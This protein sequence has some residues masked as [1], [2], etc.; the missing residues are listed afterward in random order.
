MAHPRVADARAPGRRRSTAGTGQPPSNLRAMA[1]R[2]ER[3]KRPRI[4]GDEARCRRALARYISGA[5]ELLDQAEG[6]R[7]R[8][9]ASPQRDMLER[10]RH[11]HQFDAIGPEAEWAKN[12]RRWFSGAR[13]SMV[14]YLQEQLGEVMPV[15]ALG[16]PPD[17]GKPRHGIWLDNG[18]PWLRKALEELQ[19]LQ[20]VLGVKRDVAKAGPAPARFEE[21]HASGLVSEKVINDHAKEMLS[22]RTAK[23]LHDAIGSA[24]E[25]TEA[26]LRAALDRLDVSWGPSDGLGVLMKKWR[27][28]VGELAPPDPEGAATLDRAQAA[29]ANLVTFLAEWR[30]AYGRG[31]GRAQ[32][33]PGLARRHARLAADAAETCVRFIVT[34]MDDLELLPP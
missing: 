28:A 4:Y 31:H 20:A 10:I 24:K 11:L 9:E 15:L 32:Y 25:L 19:E 27:K 26:T 22:R 7:K 1:E 2:S 18:V 34:T 8:V 14:A 3:M 17:T 30:N 12:V 29:L 5:E 33:P 23:Q 13:Q 6:V 16:L 21:L